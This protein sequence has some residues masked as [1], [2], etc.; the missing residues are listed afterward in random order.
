M[1]T[2]PFFVD[3]ENFMTVDGFD[4]IFGLASV[5]HLTWVLGALIT[6]HVIPSIVIE[7]SLEVNENPVTVNV[8]VSPPL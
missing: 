5:V 4:A 1:D 2:Y 7:I 8:T 3:L 6:E